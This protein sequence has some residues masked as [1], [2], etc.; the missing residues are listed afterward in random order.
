MN[1]ECPSC[2]SAMTVKEEVIA[3][4]F[5]LLPVR[6]AVCDDCGAEKN[7]DDLSLVGL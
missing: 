3:A 7:I 4:P 2:G 1:L 5:G 6:Y